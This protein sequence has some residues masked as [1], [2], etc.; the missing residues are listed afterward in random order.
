MEYSKIK[1]I[2]MIATEKPSILHINKATGKMAFEML[3]ARDNNQHIYVIE[4]IEFKS[5]I[6]DGDY[7]Y[8]KNGDFEGITQIKNGAYPKTMTLKKVI[9]ST[10]LE[11]NVPLINDDFLTKYI[12][13][14]NNKNILTKAN[15][16]LEWNMVTLATKEVVPRDLIPKITNNT[17]NLA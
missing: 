3:L 1:S 8:W 4:D 16:E 9:A 12:L 7:V 17:V 13:E 15:I 5:S 14:Y 2:V 10:D 6:K 11:L